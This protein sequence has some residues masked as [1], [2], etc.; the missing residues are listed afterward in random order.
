MRTDV[1]VV[2]IGINDVGM[3]METLLRHVQD[4]RSRDNCQINLEKLWPNTKGSKVSLIG[5]REVGQEA[6]RTYQRLATPKVEAH[7]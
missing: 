1:I 3:E 4:S 6:R 7:G 5:V 2:K